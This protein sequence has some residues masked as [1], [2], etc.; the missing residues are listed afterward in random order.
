M[1][2]GV[3]HALN[4]NYGRELLKTQREAMETGVGYALNL[5]FSRCMQLK[6][7]RNNGDRGRSCTKLKLWQGAIE[8]TEGS[9]GVEYGDVPW[10]MV[11]CHGIWRCAV[12]GGYSNE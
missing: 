11:A 4:L 2:T 1:E 6:T 3:G 8:D 9:N 10:N 7:Q 5:N 12:N